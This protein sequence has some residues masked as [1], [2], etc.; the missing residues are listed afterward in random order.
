VLLGR[1]SYV[2]SEPG[3]DTALPESETFPQ[4]T[5]ELRHDQL[6]AS[7]GFSGFLCNLP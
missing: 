1:P 6:L 2:H 4:V 7:N 3:A 5:A